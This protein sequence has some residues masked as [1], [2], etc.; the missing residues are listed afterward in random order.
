M[1]IEKKLKALIKATQNSD[2]EKKSRFTYNDRTKPVRD[3][4]LRIIIYCLL[5]SFSVMNV[6]VSIY[7][8]VQVPEPEFFIT[9]MDGQLYEANFI[10]INESQL[11]SIKRRIESGK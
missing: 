4:N 11:K 5:V 6:G 1:S 2:H 9:T 10:E 7:R 8:V 3:L